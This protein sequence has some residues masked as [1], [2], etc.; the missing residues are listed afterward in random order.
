MLP[1]GNGS[2]IVQDLFL[3]SDDEE[4]AGLADLEH[5]TNAPLLKAAV[6]F[7]EEWRLEILICSATKNKAL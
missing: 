4:V 7:V 1:N 5:P 6:K 2:K 3:R